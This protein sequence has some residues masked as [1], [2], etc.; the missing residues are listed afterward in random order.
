[1]S[2]RYQGAAEAAQAAGVQV[3]FDPAKERL[4][5]IGFELPGVS[6]YNGSPYDLDRL[7]RDA[8]ARAS[9]VATRPSPSTQSALV[10]PKRSRASDPTG[11]AAPTSRAGRAPLRHGRGG[12]PGSSRRA[13]RPASPAHAG[14]TT[15]SLRSR[16]G[17][18]PRCDAASRQGNGRTWGRC[19]QPARQA[20]WRSPGSWRIGQEQPQQ[21]LAGP[22]SAPN[23][24][25]SPAARSATNGGSSAGDVCGYGC[26]R[27]CSAV[28]GT[29]RPRSRRT[30]GSP[31]RLWSPGSRQ[32]V[33]AGAASLGWCT[34]RS[35][36]IWLTS[37]A[38][39]SSRLCARA[40]APRPARRID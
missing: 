37:T 36:G 39:W 11:P 16:S 35:Q 7:A 32:L 10:R 40:R 6:H 14:T 12:H 22:D 25:H 4:A 31:D 13:W 28:T 5:D 20:P 29:P 1:M 23:A 38:A 8:R 34:G 18:V 24:A 15:K 33:P 26:R 19:R 9:L 30:A 21:P 3:L 2:A 17:R 27:S